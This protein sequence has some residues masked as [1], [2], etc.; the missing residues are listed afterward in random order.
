MGLGVS[1]AGFYSSDLKCVSAFH[2]ALLS[3][4]LFQNPQSSLFTIDR[5]SGVL[6]I[7]AGE[8]LDY[9]TTKTHFVSIIAKVLSM[10]NNLHVHG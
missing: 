9:E 10:L 7:K 2:A 8:T 3:G 5:H 1:A 6:R 4:F